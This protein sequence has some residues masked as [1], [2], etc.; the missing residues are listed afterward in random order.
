[1]GHNHYRFLDLLKAIASNLIVLHHLAFYGPMIDYVRPVVPEMVE[2]LESQARIAVHAFLAIGG[3]LAAKSLSPSGM[4]GLQQPVR[5]LARRFFK[6]VP[7][8]MAAMVLAVAASALAS[9]WMTHDSISAAPTL[10]QVAAHGVLLHSVL[11]F[12][13]LSAGAWYVAIDF[14]LFASLCLILLIPAL[15]ARR[16]C[17]GWPVPPAGTVGPR[18]TPGVFPPHPGMGRIPCGRGIWDLAIRS[19]FH[20]GSAPA[21]GTLALAVHLHTGGTPARH[22]SAGRNA[23]R[24]IAPRL[25]GPGIPC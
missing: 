2:W 10:A 9:R 5:V 4:P 18:A 17:P 25:S 23:I 3:F 16:P 12:E 13:S 22:R 7:P 20:T 21:R 24:G 11:G 14:Q 19:K 15:L 1:M 8:F 6:L